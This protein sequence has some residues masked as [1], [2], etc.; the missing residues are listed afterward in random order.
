MPPLPVPSPP[1]LAG[2]E[3]DGVL[4]FDGGGAW[5][6]W[7]FD[8]KSQGSLVAPEAIGVSPYH[9][10]FFCGVAGEGLVGEAKAG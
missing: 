8:G 5:F 2:R 9:A 1:A 4:G 3:G 6:S 7:C 10:A